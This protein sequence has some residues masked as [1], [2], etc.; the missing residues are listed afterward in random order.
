[1]KL[2]ED[3]ILKD[4][5]VFA[6]D[7]LKVSHFLNHQIDSDLM[8]EIGKEIAELYKDEKI[9]KVLTVEAS[10]IAIALAT[11]AAMHVPAV[12]AKKHNTSNIKSGVYSAVVYSYTH[13][14]N[15]NIVVS[16][17]F[18][19]P[20]DRVLIVDD[21]LAR[22]NALIGLTEIVKS[23]GAQVVGCAVA[24]E[25][26]FQHG[27]DMLRDKGLR[28]ESLACIESMDDNNIVYHRF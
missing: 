28:V 6:G 12:F 22:G 10:G 2:L 7:I 16:D 13:E 18:L 11:G 20:D 24:I 8:M 1:M 27:G 23:A 25:K 15:Y 19:C 9:T 26:Y 14:R 3:R 21:L 4:G 17:E 5:K